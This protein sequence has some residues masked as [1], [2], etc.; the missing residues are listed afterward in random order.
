MDRIAIFASGTG[1]NAR[2]IIEYFEEHEDVEVA[3]VVS[4]KVSAPVL[5]MAKEFGIECLVISR[6]QFY[7]TKE[8]LHVLSEQEI[9]FIVLAGFLWLIPPYLIANFPNRIVNIH[10]A[11][12]PA[13]GGRGMYGMNVHRAVKTAGVNKTGITIHYVNERYDEGA[14]VFQ[15]SCPVQ[16]SDS[17][18]SI[19]KRVQKLEHE[20]FP[21]VIENLLLGNE[22]K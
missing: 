3:L 18:E 20:Y 10:P 22:R 1:T 13:F 12:L 17:P 19:A 16:A 5:S 15:A 9:T 4:N 7:E 2:K 6:M 21:S 14:V 11:L 8:V